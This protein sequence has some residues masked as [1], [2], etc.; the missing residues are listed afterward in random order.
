MRR[1]EKFGEAENFFDRSHPRGRWRDVLRASELSEGSRTSAAQ[2]LARSCASD[3]REDGAGTSPHRRRG[4][5][6]AALCVGLTAS[7][8]R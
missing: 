1:E 5:R 2:A 6:R 7:H 4:W 3:R 8:E